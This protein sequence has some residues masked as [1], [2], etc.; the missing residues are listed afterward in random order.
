M[1]RN[2]SLL[3]SDNYQQVKTLVEEAA[4]I[5]GSGVHDVLPVYRLPR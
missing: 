4:H 5:I 3:H 2:K 1:S